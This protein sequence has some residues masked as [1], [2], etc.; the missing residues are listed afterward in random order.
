MRARRVRFAAADPAPLGENAA[1]RFA[2]S[3]T[4]GVYPLCALY[5]MIP[6]NACSTLRYAIAHANGYVDDLSQ[7]GWIHNNSHTF[8][9]SPEFI[10]SARTSFVVLRCPF[11][12]LGSAYLHKIVDGDIVI[13]DQH[14]A[15]LDLSFRQFVQF[16]CGQPR[17]A[18]DQHWRN[19]SDF[20]LLYE[21]DHY[22]SLE[23]FSA[24]AEA[25]AA[26][27]LDLFDTRA[28]LGHDNGRLERVRGTF[29]DTPASSL[30]DMKR[31]GKA[32]AYEDLY[33]SW[34]KEAV[35]A[36]FADDL[37]LY[38]QVC[39]PQDLLFAP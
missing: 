26:M 18:R 15:P 23:R 10:A 34:C 9:A 22:F 13:M 11:R 20:L 3:F 1:H 16:A 38:A 2:A 21:Y 19:Q 36:S 7:I 4:L 39:A 17:E 31:A 6:K 32:P 28:A 27:G 30:R 5:T 8:R 12:R 33:D 35:R 37:A 14:R 24:A 29:A 25:L